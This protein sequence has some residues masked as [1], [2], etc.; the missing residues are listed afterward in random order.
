M[1]KTL[2]FMSLLACTLA[3]AA[4]SP[5]FDWRVVRGN[6]VPFEVLLP[7]KPASM[8][9]PVDL[10]AAKVEM[11]MTAAEVDGVTFAV[12]AATLPD[13]A[14]AAAALVVMKTGLVRN[15]NGSIKREAGD[16]SQAGKAGTPPLEIEAVGTRTPNGPELLLLARFFARDARVYQVLVLGPPQKVVRTEADTFFSS[17]KPE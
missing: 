16:P 2:R 3:L 4:C 5:K 8:A 9:R 1:Q 7:A 17:F 12:G 6:P 15:I 13:A 14:G 11:T 10:G